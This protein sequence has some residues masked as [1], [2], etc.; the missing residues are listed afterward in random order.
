MTCADVIFG[1]RRAGDVAWQVPTV[2]IGD[3]LIDLAD[4]TVV[5]EVHFTPIQWRCWR[6][7]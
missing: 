7:C 4:K 6:S 1:T 2:Q 5:P 3:Y